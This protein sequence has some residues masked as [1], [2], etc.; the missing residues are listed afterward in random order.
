M[1]AKAQVEIADYQYGFRDEEDYFFKSTKGLNR[2][3]VEDISAMK[4]EP[5]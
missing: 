4:G 1:V 5:A 2:K 3:R